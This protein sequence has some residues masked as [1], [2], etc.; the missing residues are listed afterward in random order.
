MSHWPRT[1]V[2]STGR[3]STATCNACNACNVYAAPMPSHTS[4]VCIHPFCLLAIVS[5]LA[6]EAAHPSELTRVSASSLCVPWQ[7]ILELKQPMHHAQ[8][9]KPT[10]AAACRRCW[11]TQRC[12]ATTVS[13]AAVS[14]LNA[15]HN[16]TGSRM[17]AKRC[18]LAHA[19]ARSFSAALHIR[20]RD[21]VAY[22]SL[23]YCAPRCSIYSTSCHHA[24]A[25]AG[26]PT[27]GRRRAADSCGLCGRAVLAQT[28]TFSA[29]SCKISCSSCANQHH[30]YQPCTPCAPRLG[31]RGWP[32]L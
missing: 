5:T 6:Q 22:A 21:C 14:T 28:P 2:D 18:T 8:H 1:A 32:T 24:P 27:R 30:L 29:S 4:H 10:T 13:T 19:P 25:S 7:S 15:E 16:S 26:K 12:C 20:I 31:A 11:Q 9:L 17:P 3:S 23:Q